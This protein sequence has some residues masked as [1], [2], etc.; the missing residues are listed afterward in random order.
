MYV[1]IYFIYVHI[2]HFPELLTQK[3]SLKMYIIFNSY[4]YPDF[5]ETQHLNHQTAK[6]QSFVQQLL[7]GGIK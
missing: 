4:L 7:P 5:Q 1:H 2:L 3:K 6:Q